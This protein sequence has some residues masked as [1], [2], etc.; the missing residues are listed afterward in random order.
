MTNIWQFFLQTAE[1]TLTAA[2]LLVLKRIFQDKLSPRWQYGIWGLLA[3]KILIPAGAG[4][5]YISMKLAAVL[6]AAKTIIEGKLNSAYLQVME[7]VTPV[8]PIP[9]VLTAPESITD[10]LFAIYV[11]GILLLLLR[12]IVGYIRLRLILRKGKPASTDFCVN[13]EQFC[14][15]HG[16]R[17]CRCM[18]L[19]GISSAFVCGVFRPVLVLSQQSER[20]SVQSAE[21]DDWDA[22][23]KKI[24]LHELLHVKYFDVLQGIFW[25]V[26]RC[27]HWCNPLVWYMAGRITCDMESLCDQRV[28]ERLSGEARRDYGML[29][30]SMTNEKYANVAGSTSLSNGGK[31]IAKRIKSIARFKKYPKGMG[32]VS[33]CICVLIA[34]PIFGSVSAME[35]PE[36]G[37]MVGWRKP[38][39]DKE[40]ALATANLCRCST[41]AGAIDTYLKGIIYQDPV[42]LRASLPAEKLGKEL[43]EVALN[44]GSLVGSKCSLAALRNLY[45]YKVYNLESDEKKEHH[46][47]VVFQWNA[48]YY[49]GEAENSSWLYTI[50]PLRLDWDGRG[51]TV[52][53]DGEA[54]CCEMKDRFEIEHKTFPQVPW[55]RQWTQEGKNGSICI[56][57]QFFQTV[58]QDEGGMYTEAKPDAVFATRT[59]CR[60]VTFESNWNEEKKK[61]IKH[62]GIQS[63]TV[64]NMEADTDDLYYAKPPEDGNWTSSEGV[65]MCGKTLDEKWDGTIGDDGG[66]FIL[67]DVENPKCAGYV[68]RIFLNKELVE[69]FKIKRGDGI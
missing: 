43:E 60:I 49:D 14:R 69:T 30:L 15:E 3:L 32:L 16:L 58:Y 10:W 52:E 36:G 11:S 63:F 40:Y 21:A 38:G 64:E 2:V 12:Y 37:V 4:G 57:E 13:L 35:L 61:G 47:Q 48:L 46:V 26:L 41:Q 55:T 45:E 54:S 19:T 6:E 9:R 39:W 1:V 31:N 50:L 42:Y 17:T 18:F 27:L 67:D 8:S 53:S 56:E 28:L 29:L 7:P 59:L 33:L 34:E 22:V 23:D 62:I 5:R 51:W 68:V 44:S 24:L 66:I 20:E 25:C 65:S